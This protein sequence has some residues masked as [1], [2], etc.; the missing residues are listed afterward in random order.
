M[1]GRMPPDVNWAMEVQDPAGKPIYRFSFR[2]EA[3]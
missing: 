2:A 1:Y 3:L